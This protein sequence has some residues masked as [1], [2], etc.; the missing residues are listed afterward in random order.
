[1]LCFFS[2]TE[3]PNTERPYT[4]KDFLLHPRRLALFHGYLIFCLSLFYFTFLHIYLQEKQQTTVHTLFCFCFVFLNTSDN[5]FSP[6]VQINN[7]CLSR[8]HKS[9]VK[10]HLRLKM[11]YLPKNSGSEEETPEQTEDTDVSW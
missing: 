6:F 4:F 8:S 1:M 2:Q 11:T 9:R 3:N 10:G 7:L 5:I